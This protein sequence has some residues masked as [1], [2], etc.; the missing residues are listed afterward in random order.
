MKLFDYWIDEP[1]VHVAF[2]R[3]FGYEK[4]KKAQAVDPIEFGKMAA[5][6][7]GRKGRPRSL[8]RAPLHLQKMAADAKKAAQGEK[9]MSDKAKELNA[10]GSKFP[11]DAGLRR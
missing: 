6:L 2:A 1:P 9:E 11:V 5:Q 8:D 10:A 4:K 3:F 7:S